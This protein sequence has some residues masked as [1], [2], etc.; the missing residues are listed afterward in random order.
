MKKPSPDACTPFDQLMEKMRL[1][2]DPYPVDPKQ[3]R[4][5]TEDSSE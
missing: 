1:G 5:E 4:E 2:M 3:D